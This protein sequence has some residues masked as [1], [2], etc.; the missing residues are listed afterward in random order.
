MN[1]WLIEGTE[2][3]FRVTR[4]DVSSHEKTVYNAD[5]PMRLGNALSFVMNDAHLGDVIKLPNGEVL[6]VA[7]HPALA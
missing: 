4:E 6:C 2:A 1:K 3:A 5:G 7:Y